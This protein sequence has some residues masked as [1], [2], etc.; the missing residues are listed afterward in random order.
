MSQPVNLNRYRKVAKKKAKEKLADENS[1][2]FGQTKSARKQNQ[3]Q[4]DLLAKKLD[5]RQLEPDD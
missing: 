3:L 2:R 5:Q 1:V 4:T